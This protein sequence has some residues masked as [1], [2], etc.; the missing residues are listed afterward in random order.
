MKKN[1]KIIKIIE[2]KLNSE[3]Q[4]IINWYNRNIQ[5]ND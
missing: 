4:M 2:I 3:A 5:A 1:N